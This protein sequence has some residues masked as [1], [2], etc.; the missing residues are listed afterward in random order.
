MRE[1]GKVISGYRVTIP[2]KIREELDIRIGDFCDIESYGQ[3]K[4][5]LTFFKVGKRRKKG[6][7]QK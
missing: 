2:D 5:L 4:V 7:N 6:E 1:R 3:D